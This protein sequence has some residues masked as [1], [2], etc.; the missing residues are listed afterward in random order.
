MEEVDIE[1]PRPPSRENWEVEAAKHRELLEPLEA[2]GFD[3]FM[4]TPGFSGY[5]KKSSNHTS[6]PYD[7]ALYLLRMGKYADGAPDENKS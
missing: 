2:I 7:M 3:V 5:W 4:H 1:K 6:I